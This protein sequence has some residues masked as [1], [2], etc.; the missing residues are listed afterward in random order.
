MFSETG[1]KCFV[2]VLIP[3]DRVAEIFS[4][5]PEKNLHLESKKPFLL[6]AG[7]GIGINNGGSCPK[8][9]YLA[10]S[11]QHERPLKNGNF[12]SSSSRRSR[13]SSGGRRK[14]QPQEYIEYFEY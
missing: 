8:A 6:L 14:F 3:N 7:Q 13:T 2:W 11:G 9:Q 5:K 4:I 10:A 1:T 12:Y